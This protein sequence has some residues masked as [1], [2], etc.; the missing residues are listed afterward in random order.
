MQVFIDLGS[1]FGAVLQKFTASKLY[2]PGCR[3]YGFECNP[4][5]LA[6]P[7]D[8]YPAGSIII[9]KAAWIENG[10]LDFYINRDPRFQ[11]SS[12]CRDKITGQLD[13]DR[14]VKIETMDFPAWLLENFTSADEIILKMNIEG[15]EYTLLPAMIMN[16]SIKLIRRLYLRRHWHKVG[17]PESADV[18]ITEALRKVPGFELFFDYNF[19]GQ[20]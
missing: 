7:L 8:K 4:V 11:G 10:T 20:R 12:V 5:V 3:L 2:K 18:G 17:I 15:A 14:P 6:Q 1:H 9:K 16:G 13:K 19:G